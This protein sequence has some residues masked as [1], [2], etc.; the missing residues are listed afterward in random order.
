M[1]VKTD[2]T[3][4]YVN[5][6]TGSQLYTEQV[7][8]SWDEQYSSALKPIGSKFRT[9]LKLT[10]G[11]EHVLF[12]GTKEHCDHMLDELMSQLHVFGGVSDIENSLYTIE[13]EL[14]EFKRAYLSRER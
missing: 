11:D 12:S 14:I 3:L 1:W 7:Y 4:C 8:T 6:E 13:C 5:T 2:D 10:C 9:V